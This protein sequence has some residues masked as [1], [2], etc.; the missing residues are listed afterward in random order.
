MRKKRRPDCWIWLRHRILTSTEA[1]QLLEFA[2]ALPLLVVLVVS[3]FDFGQAFNLKHELRNA[4][5]DGARYG[6]SLPLTDIT[7]GATPASVTGAWGLVDAYLLRSEIND[8]GLGTLGGAPVW[9]ASNSTG[10]STATGCTGTLTLTIERAYV[11]NS[12]IYSNNMDLICT[13]VSIS[14][15]YQWHFSQVIQLL[16]P[17]ST[18]GATLPVAA[19][20]LMPN[21]Q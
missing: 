1:S 2:V 9:T 3:I 6:S 19:D 4:V 14:Y 5:R 13:K 10:I 16:V 8:C 21:M 7:S 17:G 11:L 12:T 15:P 18:Y 20:A